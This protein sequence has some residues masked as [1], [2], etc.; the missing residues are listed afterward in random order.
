MKKRTNLILHIAALVIVITGIMFLIRDSSHVLRTPGYNSGAP[1]QTKLAKIARWLPK[2]MDFFV[3][4]DVPK[5]LSNPLF[6]KR[7]EGIVQRR[8]DV[9]AELIRALMHD[10][11]AVGMIVIAGKLGEAGSKSD[12][13]VI[14]QG[15]FDEK[16]LLPAIRSAMAVG[17]SGLAA[18]NLKWSTIYA[19]SDSQEPFGFMLLDQEHMAVG[20]CASLISFYEE[21][22][23]PGEWDLERASDVLYGFINIGTRLARTAPAFMYIPEAV[24]LVSSDG[25]DLAAVIPCGGSAKAYSVMMFLKGLR[26]LITIQEGPKGSAGLA[27]IL[28]DVEMETREGDVVIRT[29]LMPIVDLWVNDPK[30]IETELTR[31]QEQTR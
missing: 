12:V 17:Q 20:K 11:D 30:A 14:A 26:S 23:A 8:E 4:V 7:I 29:K 3:A 25:M 22:P 19:E 10:D 16:A 31:P 18:Q 24:Y 1:T 6:R 21:R 27:G 15:R 9:A 13:V 5:A 2:G 28:R